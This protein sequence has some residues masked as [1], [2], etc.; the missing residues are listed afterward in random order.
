MPGAIFLEGDQVNL[1]TIEEEDLKFLRDEINNPAVG[2]S[3]GP[4]FKPRNMEAQKEFFEENIASGDEVHLAI[5]AEK[6][7]KGIISIIPRNDSTGKIG[8]WIAEKFQGNGYGTE[9]SEL[10]ITYAFEELRH[11]RILAR[12]LRENKASD[13]IWKKLGFTEEG[14]FRE[15][16]Y[17]NG[18]Y[19]D[20]KLYGL[21]KN[22]LKEEQ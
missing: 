7:I 3:I 4:D 10:M 18:Q 17:R 21:L 1:R 19:E 11:H 9:A 12:T 14:A 22:E 8:L 5:S 16:V 13:K 15:H 2:K 20:L 6:E